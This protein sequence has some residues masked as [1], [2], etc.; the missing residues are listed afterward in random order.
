M[1]MVENL[2]SITRIQG[3]TGRVRKEDELVEEVVAEAIT[4]IKKRIPDIEIHVTAPDNILI[5]PMDPLLIEQVLMNL[6]ENAFVHSE[7]DGR[8]SCKYQ[9]NLI[10]LHSMSLITERELMNRPFL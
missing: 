1:N 6:M 4:R 9:K 2:L 3:D 8:L 5:I 10:P 7:T